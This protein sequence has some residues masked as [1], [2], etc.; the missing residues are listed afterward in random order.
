M[1][2]SELIEDLNKIKSEHG[3]LEV[4]SST[5]LTYGLIPHFIKKPLVLTFMCEERCVLQI[6]EYMYGCHSPNVDC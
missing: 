2:I 5:T 4:M 6:D 1:K 3:D